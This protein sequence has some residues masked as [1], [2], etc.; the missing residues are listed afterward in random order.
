MKINDTFPTN[1]VSGR[2]CEFRAINFVLRSHNFAIATVEAIIDIN[3]NINC[4][5]SELTH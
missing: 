4:R 3:V 1:K 5:I 2:E